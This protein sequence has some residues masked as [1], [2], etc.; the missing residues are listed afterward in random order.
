[1]TLGTCT[2]LRYMLNCEQKRCTSGIA[3]LGDI[4]LYAVHYLEVAFT[5]QAA[6]FRLPFVPADPYCV[7]CVAKNEEPID[8][9]KPNS[10]LREAPNTDTKCDGRRA[11]GERTR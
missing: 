8:L 4:P 10:Q 2:A 9:Q 7:P 5:H 3:L 11:D 1:M 6:F